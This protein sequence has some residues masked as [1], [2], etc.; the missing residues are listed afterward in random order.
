MQS[1]ADV[2]LCVFLIVAQSNHIR[3]DVGKN[4][5]NGDVRGIANHDGVHRLE[6]GH[7]AT[8][9]V[10]IGHRFVLSLS[11][12]VVV[13]HDDGEMVPQ[14]L[15]LLKVVEMPGVKQVKDT[16]GKNALHRTTN[17]GLGCCFMR[18]TVGLNVPA[19]PRHLLLQG[20]EYRWPQPTCGH[21]RPREHGRHRVATSLHR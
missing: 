20:R 11:N 7:H 5:E 4:V 17:H 2:F 15:G 16:D 13:G 6:P 18:M 14:R 12:G 8:T 3:F 9:E 1:G 19:P 10:L 21:Q